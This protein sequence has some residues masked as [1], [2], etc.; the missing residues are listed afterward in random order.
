MN[1]EENKFN[2]KYFE[3]RIFKIIKQYMQSSAF[4][5]R[6]LADTPTDDLSVVNRKYVNSNGTTANR[7]TGALIGQQYFDTTL[8]YPIF[9]NGSNWVNSSGTTV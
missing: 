4:T 2:D 8:G 3:D 1:Q 9:Y 6:K 5:D 7:P